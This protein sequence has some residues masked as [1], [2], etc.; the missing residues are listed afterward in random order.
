MPTSIRL[1]AVTA[2]LGLLL[3]AG[4]A[5]QRSVRG[6]VLTSDSVPAVV[7]DLDSGLTYLGTQ[8]FLL[9]GVARAEQHFFGELDGSRL[10]RLV[11]IQFEGYLPDNTHTYDYSEYPT[12]E[13]DGRPFHQN[14]AALRVPDTD[15]RPDSDGA[16]ARA[17]LRERGYTAG[18][19]LLWQRLVWLLD[20]PARN[21]L[22]VI[23]MEDLADR[24]LTAADLQPGG[25]AGDRWPAM[26]ADLL[27]RAT[28]VFRLRPR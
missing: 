18:P 4:A 17:F 24:G 9:Y 2:A 5:G 11:W 3:P 28:A 22:M 20:H 6:R 16:R 10:K 26:R 15:R 1:A 23:Y 14:S 12:V 8:S 7:M 21:E 25:P 13:V 27:R 19:D